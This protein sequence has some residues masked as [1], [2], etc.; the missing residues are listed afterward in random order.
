MSGADGDC[1]LLIIILCHI[2]ES[3]IRQAC[4]MKQLFGTSARSMLLIALVLR[5]D[6]LTDVKPIKSGTCVVYVRSP[7]AIWVGADSLTLQLK[8]GARDT[9]SCKIYHRGLTYFAFAGPT[10]VGGVFQATD[11]A[12]KSIGLNQTV[13][14]A[15]NRFVKF[16]IPL[17]ERAIP[18][19]K[20]TYPEY[21]KEGWERP[22]VPK[23]VF[24]EVVFFGF[25][26]GSTVV[27]YAAFRIQKSRDGEIRVL[28]NT[29]DCPG[30]CN[31]PTTLRVLGKNQA[32]Q[33]PFD[34]ASAFTGNAVSAIQ[35]MI[36]LEIE[37]EPKW[38]GGD[39]N[40]LRLD[41]T[42]ARWISDNSECRGK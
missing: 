38:V 34:W 1:R 28:S 33:P 36:H 22:D 18:V 23:F 2:V 25:E 21:Y 31:G 9:H 11:V 39:I 8:T 12:K 10:E 24:F 35:R 17:F 7:S 5:P 13:S 29:E 32:F 15:R 14:G 30:M 41:N 42:G 19:I 26:D 16:M 4:K 3:A 37:R 6:V 40:I 20:D 27:E